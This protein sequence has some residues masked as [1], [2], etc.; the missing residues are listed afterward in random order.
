[1]AINDCRGSVWLAGTC[2]LRRGSFPLPVYRL[3]NNVLDLLSY[4]AVLGLCLRLNN[5]PHVRGQSDL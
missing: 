3:N 2:H 4:L 5:L 1:M